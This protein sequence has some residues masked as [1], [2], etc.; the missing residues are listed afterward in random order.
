MRICESEKGNLLDATDGLENINFH[1][2]LFSAMGWDVT[3]SQD[4]WNEEGNKCLALNF[5][6][7][8]EGKRKVSISTLFG[9][10]QK[11]LENT[12]T[13]SFNNPRV[14]LD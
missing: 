8:S 7:L 12:R 2:N 9:F 4:N 6:I 10:S 14:A 13:K 3:Q 5:Y 11:N 1:E